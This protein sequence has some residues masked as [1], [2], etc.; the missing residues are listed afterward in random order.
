M[1]TTF[2]LICG[3]LLFVNLTTSKPIEQ[4]DLELKTLETESQYSNQIH[5]IVKRL[6]N[7]AK[8]LSDT[9]YAG[10]ITTEGTKNHKKKRLCEEW[11]KVPEI[12]RWRCKKFKYNGPIHIP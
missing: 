7:G 3:A 6:V 5:S 9:G 4:M 10:I 2:I 12:N 1:N 8:S 11:F